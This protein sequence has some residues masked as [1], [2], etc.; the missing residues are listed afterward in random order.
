METLPLKYDIFTLAKKQIKMITFRIEGKF[1]SP[2]IVI[3]KENRI[4]EISGRSTFNNTSWFYSNVLKWVIAFN[5][6][7]LTS[8]TIN[9]RLSKINDSSSKWILLIMR[10][11][12]ALVPSNSIT[13]NWY[14]PPHNIDMQING[15]RLKLNALVPVNLIAA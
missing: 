11:L 7:E 12:S 5:R 4:I 14:Y 8:T 10:K 9:I 13:V 6:K 2:E 3:D 1:T 15:E